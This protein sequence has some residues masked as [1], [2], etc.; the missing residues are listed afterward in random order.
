MEQSFTA[1]PFRKLQYD[2]FLTFE[3]LMFVKYQS[4]CQ[5][6]YGV[7]KATREF[8]ENNCNSI[9]NGF[10]NDGLIYYDFTGDLTNYAQLEKLYF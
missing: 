4:A 6:L 7:N 1:F 2:K 3:I 10:M 5:F 9:K 8:L